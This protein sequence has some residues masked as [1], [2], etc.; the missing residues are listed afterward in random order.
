MGTL[1]APVVPTVL[2]SPVPPP[3]DGKFPLL[4]LELVRTLR[5]ALEVQVGE[6]GGAWVEME[7]ICNWFLIISVLRSV[8]EG[9]E[10][11]E[12]RKGGVETGKWVI[13]QQYASVTNCMTS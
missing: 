10:R 3:A 2:P 9:E 6:E 4:F 8:W 13:S 12:E 5:S 1:V 7:A 11:G